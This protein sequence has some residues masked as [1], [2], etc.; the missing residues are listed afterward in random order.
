MLRQR[1]NDSYGRAFSSILYQSN[2]SR[3]TEEDFDANEDRNHDLTSA[4]AALGVILYLNDALLRPDLHRAM[5]T[6]SG[7]SQSPANHGNVTSSDVS[8]IA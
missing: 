3:G 5:P 6:L 4:A 1:V 8:R 7:A 2:T